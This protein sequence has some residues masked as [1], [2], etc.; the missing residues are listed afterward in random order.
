MLTILFTLMKK[1]YCTNINA[2]HRWLNIAIHVIVALYDV[3]LIWV[4][5][6]L[7]MQVQL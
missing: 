1:R 6:V 4:F 2:D 7:S 5:M 3:F